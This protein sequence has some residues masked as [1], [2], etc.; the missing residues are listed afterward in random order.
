MN[1]ILVLI[2]K[3]ADIIKK[4]NIITNIITIN[5]G[6]IDGGAKKPSKVKDRAIYVL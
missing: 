5:R 1:I 6:M 3:S 4:S 2:I